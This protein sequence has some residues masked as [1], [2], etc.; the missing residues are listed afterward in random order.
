M[1][2]VVADTV[3]PY[4]LCKGGKALIS[5]YGRLCIQY[6]LPQP[7]RLQE[8]QAKVL[9]KENLPGTFADCMPVLCLL[10]KDHAGI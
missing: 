4:L 8:Q 1:L 5:S 7:S 3:A 2:Q 10:H 6:R 9:L